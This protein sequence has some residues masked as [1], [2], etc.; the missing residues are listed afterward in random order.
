M[1]KHLINYS[2][3]TLSVADY[4][5]PGLKNYHATDEIYRSVTGKEKEDGHGLNGY[6]LLLHIGKDPKERINFISG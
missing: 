5:Y 3:G 4:T 1:G 2:P 6:L